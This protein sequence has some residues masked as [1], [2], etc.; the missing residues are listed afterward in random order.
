MTTMPAKTISHNFGHLASKIL[1]PRS[2]LGTTL[3]T[4]H[5]CDAL[6]V[7][8]LRAIFLFR[9]PVNLAFSEFP[10]VGFTIL[11]ASK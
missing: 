1:P 7:R 9:A 10:E 3:I 2:P 6:L 11:L 8:P 4:Q 5:D